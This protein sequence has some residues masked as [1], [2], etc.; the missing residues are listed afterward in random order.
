MNA[1]NIPVITVDGPSGSGKGTL[2]R[3][4]AKHFGYHLL[5]SGALY[6]L[7][8]IATERA[9]SGFGDEKSAALCASALK[10]QFL[11]NDDGSERIELAGDD[12][13][14]RVRA[15][16]TGNKASKVAKHPKVREALLELQYSFRRAPGLIA[17][18][19]DMGT[20]IFPDAQAKIFLTASA[21]ERAAR[22]V[23]QM[24][25]I[26]LLPQALNSD[27]LA[28][29]R[30]ETAAE[31]RERDYRDANRTVAPLVPAEDA[32]VID[33]TGVSIEKVVKDVIQY[34]E[35]H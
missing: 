28:R 23:S 32:Q 3:Q 33:T 30:A 34:I 25:Q 17:D 12:V 27:S 31:I 20:I 7:T 8:A 16:E 5:D 11:V 13:T 24:Q 19:R 6:R 21:D 15:E 2:C 1:N 14:K 22:R 9:G 10:V 26:G 29:L 18:G 4:L 35:K